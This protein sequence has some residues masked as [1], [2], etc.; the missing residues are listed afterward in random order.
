MKYLMPIQIFLIVFNFSAA[1]ATE[2]KSCN[3]LLTNPIVQASPTQVNLELQK[4][5]R[6]E[7]NLAQEW[8]STKFTKSITPAFE[9]FTEELGEEDMNIK[10]S[11]DPVLKTI[12]MEALKA[13]DQ[14]PTLRTSLAPISEKER[15]YFVDIYQAAWS[16]LIKHLDTYSHGKLKKLDVPR[17]ILILKGIS[18]F[19]VEKAEFSFY[20][21]KRNIEGRYSFQEFIYCK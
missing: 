7:W 16:S 20:K 17:L 1:A 9:E 19:Q 5:L 15:R 14:M 11:K 21:I 4:S 10:I 18:G 2:D 12:L 13:A 3:S 8:F 6:K